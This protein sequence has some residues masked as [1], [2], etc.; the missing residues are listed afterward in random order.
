MAIRWIDGVMRNSKHTGTDLLIMLLLAESADHDTGSCYPG[1]ETLARR[2][3]MSTRN[4]RYR[5]AALTN[6]GEITV[7]RS[8][9]HYGTNI[10]VLNPELLVQE[11]VDFRSVPRTMGKEEVDFRP[12]HKPDRKPTADPDRKRTSYKPSV[13]PSDDKEQG[14]KNVYTADF[15]SFWSVWPKKGD[16]RKPSHQ[17]WMRLTIDEKNAAA[18]ALPHW[19][20]YYQSIENRLIPNCTTWLNQARWENEPPPVERTKQNG[21][22]R[23]GKVD[24]YAKA[25]EYEAEESSS[26]IE[27]T[28]RQ[29]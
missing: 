3:R 2:A 11:E 9:S 4:L 12:T 16:A 21:A 19:L 1:Q 23:N 10:Y 27:T 14:K 29:S 8:K 24:W 15:D 17:S 18:S 5:L 28:W 25:A 6:N 13:E 22:S 7:M 20:P 26:I